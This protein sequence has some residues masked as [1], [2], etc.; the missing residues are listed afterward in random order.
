MIG[1]SKKD[2]K[3]VEITVSN[4]TMIRIIGSFVLAYLGLLALKN[5]QYALVLIGVSLFLA[6]ALNSPVNWIAKRTPGRLKGNRALAT[7]ISY[8]F[9]ISLLIT[10]IAN[11]VPPLAKQTGQFIENI[12]ALVADLRD[13]DTTL[14][15]FVQKYN[16]ESQVDKV[17][18][19]LTDR[20]DDI[21][22]AAVGTITR[23]G[24][25]FFAVITVLVLTFMMLIEGPRW[26]RFGL[27]LAPDQNRKHWQKL[28]LDMYGVI[29]GYVNGQVVLAAVAALFILIPLL[30]MN[31]SYP[32]A[33]MV[34]VF[35]CGLIP[36]VGHTIGATIVTTVALF[37]SLIAAL[38][39]LGYYILYQQ[40]EN[41]VVQP[42]I[43]SNTTN[44]S[45]LLVLI[46][47]TIG[48]TFGG[49]L[50][51]LIAI[52]LGGCIRVLVLDY[53]ERTEKLSPE[54]ALEDP[55]GAYKK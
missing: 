26:V 39:I 18:D 43:Q 12:P 42:K 27:R 23:I 25:S 20:L 24:T 48:V 34:I 53:L 19:Q 28:A 13:E 55:I 46:S 17:S 33:L 7:T 50:G 52:P 40:I 45:P 31:I 22:G 1:F 51:G 29:K 9:V 11:L 4:Q 21:G 2:T 41:Y 6:L 44:L 14:G 8:I 32:A 54:S 5:A 38:I 30:I 36:M 3:K 37:Q 47:V 16:L 49:I 35:V 10:F 15:A